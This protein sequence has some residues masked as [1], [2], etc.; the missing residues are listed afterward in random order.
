MAEIYKRCSAGPSGWPKTIPCSSYRRLYGSRWQSE[1]H[2]EVREIL[3]G[4][5]MPLVYDVKE[6]K[7]TELAVVIPDAY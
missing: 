4:N 5:P 3:R 6:I 2:G 7:R 1:K